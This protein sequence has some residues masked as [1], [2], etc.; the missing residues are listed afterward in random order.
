MNKYQQKILVVSA[1]I[2]IFM[3]LFP[4]FQF[5]AGNG[6]LLNMGY[7]FL[8][9]PPELRER[10][11]ATVNTGMLLTQWLAVVLVGA[12]LWFVVREKD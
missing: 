8:F 5:H 10:A 3:L 11:V 4:P 7:G 2:I 1:A 12:I 9:D 6:A